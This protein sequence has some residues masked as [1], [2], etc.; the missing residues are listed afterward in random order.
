MQKFI[1]TENSAVK[2]FAILHLIEST[3]IPCYEASI[4]SS[5]VHFQMAKRMFIKLVR[6]T[7]TML[8][9]EQQESF[10][11]DRSNYFMKYNNDAGQVEKFMI[12]TLR[13]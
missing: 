13:N 11:Y 5:T 7:K 8:S 3:V 10:E 1:K 9:L 4:L 6:T 12:I 2:K